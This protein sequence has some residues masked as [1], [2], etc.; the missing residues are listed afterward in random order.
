MR[1]IF[2]AGLLFLLLGIAT[3]AISAE[4]EAGIKVTK[5]TQSFDTRVTI[6]ANIEVTTPNP[7][8]AK[9]SDYLSLWTTDAKPIR[10]QWRYLNGCDKASCKPAVGLTEGKVVFN[11][12][13][14]GKYEIRL[15]GWLSGVAGKD[16]LKYTQDLVVGNFTIAVIQYGD[17][18]VITITR[19]PGTTSQDI[20]SIKRAG[21][22]E[23]K[24]TLARS[25]SVAVVKVNVLGQHTQELTTLNK[26]VA[27]VN[28]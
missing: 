17:S 3:F 10:I 18:D 25:I 15:Y 14:E 11:N 7:G 27:S 16:Q 1:S 26:P 4:P 20:L 13:P 6:T 2:I 12:I 24:V 8:E 22:D 28:P 9:P 19:T 5:T 23:D 21:G